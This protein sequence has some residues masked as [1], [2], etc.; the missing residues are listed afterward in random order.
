MSIDT[1]KDTAALICD[2]RPF[3]S[4]TISLNIL[5]GRLPENLL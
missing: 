5:G 3:K 1:E 4:A 2:Y